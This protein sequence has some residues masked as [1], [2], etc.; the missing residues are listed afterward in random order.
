MERLTSGLS[1]CVA[2][3]SRL[4][5]DVSALRKQAAPRE[6]LVRSQ[7]DLGG[8]AGEARATAAQLELPA[9][10]RAYPS[11]TRPRAEHGHH[12]QLPS[13]RWDD[14]DVIQP[15]PAHPAEHRPHRVRRGRLVAPSSTAE[16]DSD[17]C[18]AAGMIKPR[19]P[20]QQPHGRARRDQRAPGP[21]RA[22]LQPTRMPPFCHVH[23]DFDSEARP[24][25]PDDSPL[26]RRRPPVRP[27]AGACRRHDRRAAR[28]EAPAGPAR[29]TAPCS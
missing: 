26:R 24:T 14:H 7:I 1:R 3:W 2:S 4:A 6:A 18:L 11:A 28:P 19:S 17:P 5:S 9:E 29:L 16:D 27:L 22:H 23:P 25:Q 12:R 20:K 15:Q 10:H 21:S 13:N 8:V